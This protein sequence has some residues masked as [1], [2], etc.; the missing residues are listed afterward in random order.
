MKNEGQREIYLP[1]VSRKLKH[2]QGNGLS[3][4]SELA[5]GSLIMN[6]TYGALLGQNAMDQSKAHSFVLPLASLQVVKKKTTQKTTRKHS[7]E[8]RIAERRTPY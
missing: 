5:S 3:F 6:G 2:F 1:F 4:C 7:G 8:V